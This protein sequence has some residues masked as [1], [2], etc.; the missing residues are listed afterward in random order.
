[1]VSADKKTMSAAEK[2]IDN[3]NTSF[4]KQVKVTLGVYEVIV[5]NNYNIGI[6]LKTSNTHNG[7]TVTSNIINNATANILNFSNSNNN[8]SI[9]GFLSSLSNIG[10][11]VNSNKYYMLIRNH[12]PY[13]KKIIT[14]TDYVKSVKTTTNT[15]TGLTTQNTTQQTNTV[16]EGFSITMIPNIVGDTISLN[17]SPNIT[18]L[19]EMKGAVYNNSKITLPKTSVENFTT[20]VILKD[21]EKIVIGSVTTY[22]KA[23]NYSGIIPLNNFILGGNSSDKYVRK[24]TVFVLSAKIVEK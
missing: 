21:G 22:D 13:N 14:S 11:V 18:S 1:M 4:L 24:E 5:K 23:N 7:K 15:N 8:F 19:L 17:I 16:N 9:N 2:I 3:F 10:D 12:L 6:D 20:E